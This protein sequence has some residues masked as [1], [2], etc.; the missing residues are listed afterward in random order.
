MAENQTP[1]VNLSLDD[2]EKEN[3]KDP[4]RITLRGRVIELQDPQ[5][6]DWLV[7]AELEDDP[8]RFVTECMT[9][10]DADFFMEKKLESWKVEELMKDF[11][12][13]YGLGGR[14]KGR[15]SRR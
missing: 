12:R 3:R 4:Y 14:G 8:V 13:Y 7:L 9:D 15:G 5:D 6:I 2:L 11:M 10:D 1:K